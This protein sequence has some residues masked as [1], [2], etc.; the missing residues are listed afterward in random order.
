MSSTW[1]FITCQTLNVASHHS[2][3]IICNVEMDIVGHFPSNKGQCNFLLVEVNYFMKWIE[4]KPL[5]S[6]STKSFKSLCGRTSY[7]NMT[8]LIP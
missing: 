2:F 4:I 5:T 8:H 6:I 3:M 7:T 1:K